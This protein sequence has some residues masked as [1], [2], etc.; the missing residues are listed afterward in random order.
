MGGWMDVFVSNWHHLLPWLWLWCFLR[1]QRVHLLCQLIEN[2]NRIMSSGRLCAGLVMLGFA[3]PDTLILLLYKLLRCCC[4]KKPLSSS[5]NHWLFSIGKIL[6]MLSMAGVTDFFNP[7]RVRICKML[8]HS[9]NWQ[10]CKTYYKLLNFANFWATQT[11]NIFDEEE[12]KSFNTIFLHKTSRKHICISLT[13]VPIFLK[14][15]PSLSSLVAK[16]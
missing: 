4:G 5:I 15:T 13:S 16:R 11:F 12:E 1:Q 3:T 10:H 14:N 7:K 9:Q 8:I 2:I 6:K